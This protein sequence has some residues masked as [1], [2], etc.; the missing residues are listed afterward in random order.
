MFFY[1][2]FALVWYDSF[3]IFTFFFFKEKGVLRVSGPSFG[4]VY[5]YK[6][7]VQSV[8]KTAVNFAA[9][10]HETAILAQRYEFVHRKFSH[11]I[12][13]GFAPVFNL[14]TAFA[15]KSRERARGTR[16]NVPRGFART[17]SRRRSV[18]ANAEQEIQRQVV[19]LGDEIKVL[20]GGLFLPAAPIGNTS[21]GNAD[22]SGELPLRNLLFSEEFG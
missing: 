15:A 21:G 9:G 14:F 8:G 5:F 10:E 17:R 12:S 1:L 19:G 18:I 22:G 6:I 11:N 7:R 16:N 3:S 2:I 4:L 20:G 13:L